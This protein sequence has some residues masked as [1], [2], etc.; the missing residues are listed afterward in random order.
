MKP[1]LLDSNAL[2]HSLAVLSVAFL[3]GAPSAQAAPTTPTSDFSD[4]GD[5]TVTHNIT[6]LT[7][8]RCAEGQTWSGSTCSGTTKTYSWAQANALGSGDWRLPTVAEL[9]TI[10]ERDNFKPAI[11]TTIFPNMATSDSSFWSASVYAGDLSQAWYVNFG[12][13]NSYSFSKSDDPLQVRL[14]RGGRTR[15]S[16]GGRTPTADFID[17]GDG[18]VTHK[19][20]SLTWKRCA[21][22]LSWSG[23]ECTGTVRT[24]TWNAANALGGDGWRLPTINELQTLV[25]Y[26]VADPGPTINTTIF[27]DMSGAISEA[28][29]W[30]ASAFAGGLGNAWD[31]NFDN[32]ADK[33]ANKEDGSIVRLVRGRQSTEYFSGPDCLFF[34]AERNFPQYFSPSGGKSLTLSGYYYRPYAGNTYLGTSRADN[35]FI[36]ILGDGIVH[37]A[38]LVSQWYVWTGCQP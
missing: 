7:W 17:N 20:T 25:E 13:G 15:D 37:D 14:V 32:G 30:S 23:S 22:G 36:F 11:N 3:L 34:W 4:N 28:N 38:G 24:Y 31:I 26:A 29:F 18:S 21:E 8:K 16:F 2:R 6:G 10:V 19:Q 35:R 27:P 5:G 33:N 12:P 1:A 9:V